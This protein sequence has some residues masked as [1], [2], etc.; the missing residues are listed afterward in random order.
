MRADTDQV[1]SDAQIPEQVFG[2]AETLAL[3][4]VQFL[5]G[6]KGR[7]VGHLDGEWQ[8]LFIGHAHQQ[9]ANGIGYCQAHGLEYFCGLCLGLARDPSAYDCLCFLG[10]PPA[11]QRFDATTY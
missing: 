8:S 1:H 9:Q 10:N 6:F 3:A 11:R 7:D 2:L 5:H 4:F